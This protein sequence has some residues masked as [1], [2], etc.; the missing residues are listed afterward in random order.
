MNSRKIDLDAFAKVDL[1]M[2]PALSLSDNIAVETTLRRCNF[3]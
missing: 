3:K 1:K 2:F